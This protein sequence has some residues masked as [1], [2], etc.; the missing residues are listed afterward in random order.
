M[1]GGGLN[2]RIL[3]RHNLF[4]NIISLENLFLAWREFKRGKMNKRDVQEFA[5][6]L[7]DN[8]F[9]LNSQLR[10][11]SYH[12]SAYFSFYVTDPKLRHIH[13]ARV[14]D[15]VLHHAVFRILCPIFEKGFI[16][17]SYSCRVE[18]GT[19]RAI[20]RLANFL[21][22]ASRNNNKNIFIAK[23]DVRKFFD[24]V[25]HDILL[26]IIR[27]RVNG[28]R[29]MW[30]LNEIIA[31]SYGRESGLGLPMG[32]VTSQLFAN[33]Y[34]NELDQFVKHNLKKKLYIR[35]CDDFILVAKTI[36]ELRGFIY[37]TKEFLYDHLGL[38][39]HKD[40]IIIR[41]YRQG[42]DFLGYV[43]LPHCRVLRTKTKKRMLI[44]M[45]K[46]GQN[47]NSMQSYL[48]LLSHGNTYKIRTKLIDLVGDCIS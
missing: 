2:G 39:L 30:L 8:L 25:R 6:N 14:R 27:R 3:A 40:K 18:K 4:E 46:N 44:K 19:H 24:S 36:E 42:V 16:F 10:N 35:Y 34:L 29:I 37:D 12:H 26:A 33:I 7:E 22:K 38:D 17:D 41:T 1:V 20:N 13:K 11:L 47:Q 9:C 31:E 43:L 45:I 5:L 15:R 21:D 23:L 48:G 28:A 32:N